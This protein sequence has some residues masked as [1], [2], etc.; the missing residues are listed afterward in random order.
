M[1]TPSMIDPT[2]MLLNE[3]HVGSSFADWLEEEGLTVEVQEAAIKELLV[4]Q[5]LKAMRQQ[6]MTRTALAAALGTSRNQVGRILDPACD[7]ITLGAVKRA[8]AAVG[9]KV[10]IELV[11]V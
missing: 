9:K 7:G 10:K 3:A 11:D 4:E 8:A 1:S 5:L 6:E 2:A